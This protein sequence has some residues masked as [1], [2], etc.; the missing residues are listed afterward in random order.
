MNETWKEIIDQWRGMRVLVIG[1]VMLDVY[2][3]GSVTRMGREAMAP[4]VDVQGTEEVPGGAANTAVNAAMLGAEVRLVGVMGIEPEGV[5]LKELLSRSAVHTEWI[6][7]EEEVFTLVKTRVIGNQQMLLRCDTGN[8]YSLNKRQERSLKHRLESCLDWAD[9]VIISDYGYGTISRS[10]VRWLKQQSFADKA[11]T[12]DAKDLL[13]FAGLPLTA[14]K[15]NYEQAIAITHQI[16][17]SS[18]SKRL[19]Q[20]RRFGEVILSKTKAALVAVTLDK[21]GALVFER[22]NGAYRTYAEPVEGQKTIG[23]G[24]T[25]TATLALALGAKASMP[26]VAEIAAA[27]AR[28]VVAKDGTS[29]CTREELMD[30][31]QLLHKTVANRKAL[32]KLANMYRNQGKRIVFTN[33]C[34]DL[35]HR[36]HVTY[37]NQAKGLGEVLLVAVNSD[38]SV[39]R[40]KGKERPINRLQDRM[41]VLQGLSSVDHVVSFEEETPIELIKVVRPDVYVKGGDYDLSRLPEAKWVHIYGGRVEILP[42]LADQSTTS[43]IQKI[44]QTM[45]PG[46]IA[47]SKLGGL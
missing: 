36:G 23:A 29:Y 7:Q 37:L 6:L 3:R 19:E 11:L 30:Y 16:P 25:Y 4:I 35:I 15:P 17:A 42:Y 32:A 12:V 44:K 43:M 40:L 21:D 47:E 38:E 46:R 20:V 13:K 18:T 31:S 33:G 27:A 14:V 41:E 9:V 1:D 5:R 34:F 24:D 8:T 10:L 26:M 45:K 22:G 2:I 39:R 28:T